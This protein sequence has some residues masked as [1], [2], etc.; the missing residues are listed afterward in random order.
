M[1]HVVFPVSFICVAT[2]EKFYTVA[3]KL[4]I[5]KRAGISGSISLCKLAFTMKLVIKEV[6]NVLVSI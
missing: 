2:F 6:S 3:I 4:V 1:L 5:F